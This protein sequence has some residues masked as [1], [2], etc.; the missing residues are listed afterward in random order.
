MKKRS[1]N[2]TQAKKMSSKSTKEIIV[3]GSQG[4]LGSEVTE[5][6]KSLN[7]HVIP[8]DR[9]NYK[10]YIGESADLL[11][12]CNGN[13]YRFKANKDPSQDFEDNV[14]SVKNSLF[15]FN[16]DTYVYISTVDVYP[17]K[18][19]IKNTNEESLI[20]TLALDIYGFHKRIA[21]QIVSKYSKKSL[22][23][24]AGTLIG[25]RLKKGPIYDILNR[26][27]LHMS[28]MS[29]L[30]LV[31]TTIVAKAIEA[32]LATKPVKDIYNVTGKTSVSLLDIEDQIKLPIKK[33]KI[34]NEIIYEYEINIGKLEK[35]IQVPSSQEMVTNFINNPERW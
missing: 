33:P 4:L 14:L 18:N 8:I 13:A 22:I 6:F 11:I 24:R 7:H 29:K 3:L 25:K 31:D 34:T 12:N 10:N 26:K 35:L 1:I 2:Q 5:Y 19:S 28:L 30:S 16:V 17:N 23:I 9:K 32:I 15:D 20:D 21:E 27:E